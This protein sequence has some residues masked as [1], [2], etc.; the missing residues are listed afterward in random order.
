MVTH[1]RSVLEYVDTVYEMKKGKLVRLEAV[2][3]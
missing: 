2:V 3:L 1:D